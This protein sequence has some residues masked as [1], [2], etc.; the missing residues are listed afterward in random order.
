MTFKEIDI[1]NSPRRAHFDHFRHAPNPHVGVTVDVDVTDF[2]RL[3]REKG[4]SF[5]LAF[6]RIA[7]QSANAVPEL[8]RRIW[9]ERVLEYAS[10][11]T[12]H[13]E[14]LENGAYCYCTLRHDPAQSWEDYMR[15]AAAQR[16]RARAGA[17]IEEEADVESLYFISTIPWLHYRDFSQPNYGP[18]SS[19]P[20][21]TWGR[22]E[23]DYRGRLMMPVSLLAHHSLVDGINI[24]AFYENLNLCLKRISILNT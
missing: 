8:R 16:E 2:V 19:N 24:A 5:Y 22:Y 12:S 20:A 1:S 18:D 15:Y 10:C 17:S 7:A 23:P 3:C 14:L 11:D 9:G 21:I 13:I 4:W 6:I